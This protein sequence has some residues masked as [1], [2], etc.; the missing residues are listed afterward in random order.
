MP[1]SL[2]SIHNDSKKPYWIRECDPVEGTSDLSETV[3]VN[4][5]TGDFTNEVHG[6]NNRPSA[7]LYGIVKLLAMIAD[8]HHYDDGMHHISDPDVIVDAGIRE[9]L[10]KLALDFYGTTIPETDEVYQSTQ[11]LAD[12]VVKLYGFTSHIRRG[13]ASLIP[14]RRI[15]ADFIQNKSDIYGFEVKP[16]LN[17][18]NYPIE[19]AP[20]VS[21]TLLLE[22]AKIFLRGTNI[23]P[24]DEKCYVSLTELSKTTPATPEADVVF[25]E[26]KESLLT[27]TY[28]PYG[29]LQYGEKDN[30]Q[31]TTVTLTDEWVEGIILG[32]HNI[33]ASTDTEIVQLQY[34][35]TV[36]KFNPATSTYGV[37]SVTTEDGKAI[38]RAGNSGIWK[39][40]DDSSL[41]IPVA[42]VGKKNL[43]LYDWMLN[44]GGTA[45]LRSGAGIPNSEDE[46]FV[47]NKIAYFNENGQEVGNYFIATYDSETDTYEYQGGTYYRA[48]L[49][50]TD[51][52]GHPDGEFAD[53]LYDNNIVYIAKTYNKD[54]DFTTNDLTERLLSNELHLGLSP[55][56]KESASS[57][58]PGK[59]YQKRPYQVYAFSDDAVDV[60]PNTNNGGLYIDESNNGISAI[61][62]DYRGFWSDRVTTVKHAFY[63]TEGDHNSESKP[64]L[65]Y[66]PTTQVVVLNTT[67]MSGQPLISSSNPPTL[68]WSDDGSVVVLATPWSGLDTTTA[69]CNIDPTGHTGVVVYGTAHFDFRK[70][71][72][73]PFMVDRIIKFQNI[74]G[75]VYPS[76][77]MDEGDKFNTFTFAGLVQEGSGSSI[78]LGPSA[79]SIDGFYVDQFLT[80]AHSGNAAQ[81]QVFKITDYAGGAVTLNANLEED[82][83][84]TAI[85]TVSATEPDEY[86]VRFGRHD[87]SIYGSIRRKLVQADSNGVF[88]SD[89]PMLAVSN[90]SNDGAVVSGLSPNE[91][92]DVLFLESKP[93]QDGFYVLFQHNPQFYHFKPVNGALGEM[94][95]I[96][97]GTFFETTRGSANTER[98]SYRGFVPGYTTPPIDGQKWVGTVEDP[99]FNM[100]HIE[101]A[102][103]WD[104]RPIENTKLIVDEGGIIRTDKQVADGYLQCK[105][106][107]TVTN[108]N[109]Q[110]YLGTVVVNTAHGKKMLVALSQEGEFG[111]HKTEKCFV[112]DM[113]K[114]W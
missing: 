56:F 82:I 111:F 38:V 72:G 67:A 62:D 79:S 11:Q 86:Y 108:E 61:T 47:L 69:T 95:I 113:D 83:D 91:G 42:V 58:I 10:G 32:H 18:D 57:F 8:D 110:L 23:D 78:V 31:S 65:S 102:R 13:I 35:M 2:T 49:Q 26:I 45:I 97:P 70:G 30:Y 71:S 104:V 25:I 107:G 34:K 12:T 76:F 3:A 50:R 40:I 68:H 105:I 20:I 99:T 54:L 19:Q 22:G 21:G 44:P 106:E 96:K 87:R 66:S 41:I 103:P 81:G 88:S 39:T 7:T 46:C 33:F 93:F 27:D 15:I 37:D 24:D 101:N 5:D 74:D 55:C 85:V 80:V 114:E 64:F 4:N 16:S 59:F 51:R 29:N 6:V 1:K 14:Y 75:T 60:L 84:D 90:G 89:V 77:M 52:T 98:G 109:S 94:T 48:G 112:L 92:L 63:F 17:G 36:K 73:L 43:G 53:Y 9:A 100:D 28:Y